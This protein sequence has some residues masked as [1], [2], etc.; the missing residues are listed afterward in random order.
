M[1]QSSPKLIGSDELQLLLHSSTLL[2]AKLLCQSPTAEERSEEFELDEELQADFAQA[3]A[4]FAPRLPVAFSSSQVIA[5]LGTLASVN[6]SAASH[7]ASELASGHMRLVAAI[8]K[9]RKYVY[10]L[11]VPEPLLGFAAHCLIMS[12][13]VPWHVVIDKYS[14]LVLNNT[15]D[16]GFRGEV[17]GQI[18]CLV[19]WQKCLRRRAEE[20]RLPEFEFPFIPA[21]QFIKAL[22]G[23]ALYDQLSTEIRTGLE[24][25]LSQAFVRVNQFAKTYVELGADTLREFFVR[26]SGVYC[27]QGQA[28]VDLAI[29]LWFGQESFAEEAFSVLLLQLKLRMKS[30]SPADLQEWHRKLESL[31][32]IREIHPGRPVV[33][34][35]LELGPPRGAESAVPNMTTRSGSDKASH[36]A[37]GVS[38]P[39]V[40]SDAAGSASSTHVLYALRFRNVSLANVVP[41]D[42]EAEEAFKRLLESTIDPS[43]TLN[44][45]KLH[46]DAMTNVFKLP[47]MDSRQKT[48]KKRKTIRK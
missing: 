11:E 41:E 24:S 29:P 22:V 21:I 40:V 45:E 8:S 43:T 37:D 9:Q 5:V 14:A 36:V 27:K 6:I 42:R 48:N 15:T 32:L 23:S 17:A 34:V 28:A 19:A 47:F 35:C 25:V 46:R 30:L 16:V 39:V 44:V 13:R 12:G 7:M 18:L 33:A 2:Q 4:S 10:T 3:A 26:A 20:R 31:P 1:L 38:T